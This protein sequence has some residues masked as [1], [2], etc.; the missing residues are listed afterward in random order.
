MFDDFMTFDDFQWHLSGSQEL[1]FFFF[2]RLVRFESEGLMD[3]EGTS[4]TPV[5]QESATVFV[6]GLQRNLFWGKR[7]LAGPDRPGAIPLSVGSMCWN[8]TIGVK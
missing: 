8:Q 1:T 6:G 2:F 4:Q 7:Y 5:P 3:E